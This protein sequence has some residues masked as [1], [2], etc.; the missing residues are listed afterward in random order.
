MNKPTFGILG[1]GSQTTAFY[2]KEL[3]RVFN[4]KK[5]GYST[6]PF[7]LLNTDFDAINSL[8]PNVSD[9]LNDIIQSYISELEKTEIEHLLVPNITLHETIDRLVI[10]KKI[11]HPIHLTVSKIKQNKWSKIVLFGSLYTMRSDYIPSIFKT[12]GIETILPSQ[13]DMLIIDEVRKQI[14][15]NKETDELIKKYHLMI[16]KYTANYAVILACT[17]LSIF[18]P[19]N[20]NVLDMAQLQIEKAVKTVLSNTN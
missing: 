12:N 11:I 1:L 3:N 13:K 20:K 2:L 18:K 19:K 15:A 17:E 7:I 8:L 14:Y 10:E 4:E 9:E 16:E 6:R 5:G